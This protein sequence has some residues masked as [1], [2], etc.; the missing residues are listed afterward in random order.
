MLFGATPVLPLLAC[1][2][3]LL[4]RGCMC[5]V[6]WRTAEGTPAPPELMQHK[7]Y[8]GVVKLEGGE[9]PFTSPTILP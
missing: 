7:Q 8:G 9:C 2:V 5:M 4:M 3:G 6:M 1:S